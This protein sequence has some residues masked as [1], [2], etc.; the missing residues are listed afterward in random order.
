MGERLSIELRKLLVERKLAY[1]HA[2]REII[3][4]EVDGARYDL[5]RSKKSLNDKDYKWATIQ[6]YY[7]MFH[8][9]RALLFSRGYREKS[10]RALLIALNEL[11]VKKGQ[12]DNESY[13][14]LK[15][16]MDLREDADY[17]MTFS[18]AS[19]NDV[20][21]RAEKF[22]KTVERILQV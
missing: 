9:A 19:A 13:D 12:L 15:V 22:L 8:L 1:F 16:A 6:A 7:C 17:G 10:H 3:I 2:S 11:F 4:K 20:T 21:M 14:N 5:E 18:E